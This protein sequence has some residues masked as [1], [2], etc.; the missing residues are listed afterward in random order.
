M[1]EVPLSQ[2]KDDLSRL[3]REAEKLEA[4][5]RFLR[6][7]EKARANIRAGRGVRP[8]DMGLG[9]AVEGPSPHRHHRNPRVPPQVTDGTPL[10]DPVAS[11]D[12]TPSHRRRAA[13]TSSPS[14]S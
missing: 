2:V 9:I 14:Q 12:L 4:D 7:I 8:E 5:P 1:K 13:P 6:R 11:N 10:S 3:L